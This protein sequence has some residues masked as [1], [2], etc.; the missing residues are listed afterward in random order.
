MQLAR[1]AGCL[2]ACGL[3]TSIDIEL[4]KQIMDPDAERQ[5]ANSLHLAPYTLGSMMLK[6]FRPTAPALEFTKH[7]GASPFSA[8]GT[9]PEQ[10]R[11]HEV[12]E[13]A[14]MRPV[15]QLAGGRAWLLSSSCSYARCPQMHDSGVAAPRPCAALGRTNELLWFLGSTLV[16]SKADEL[17]AAGKR[18][19]AERRTYRFLPK[20]DPTDLQCY[21]PVPQP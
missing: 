20:A 21:A 18:Q 2:L 12:Q 14:R 9:W 3:A 16:R 11:V 7:V 4:A 19:I 10:H 8:P 5:R 13:A 1:L 17:R 15:V 6:H